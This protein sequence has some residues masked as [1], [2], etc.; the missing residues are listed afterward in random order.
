MAFEEIKPVQSANE[1]IDIAIRHAN[2][3]VALIKLKGD[4]L[5]KLKTKELRRIEIIRDVLLARLENVYTQFPIIKEL[6]PFYKEMIEITIGTYELKKELSVIIWSKNQ[7]KAFFRKYNIKLKSAKSL[8]AVY[9]AKKAYYGRISSVVKKINFQFLVNARKTLQSFPVIKS[10]YKQIAITGFP[11][12]GKST[13]L[14][15]ITKSKPEIAAYPFTTKGIMIGYTEKIQFLDTPGT[16]N[17]QNKM[18]YIELMAFLVMKHVAEKI[19]YIFD[20]TESYPLKDQIR[21][22]KRIKEFKKP[23]IIYLSKT[24]ILEKEKI[25]EFKEKYPKAVSDVKE[26]KKNLNN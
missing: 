19:I 20:L 13:L 17:R 2:K 26:L 14:S 12:V 15:K 24:D 6:T 16:L 4:R 21:L 18:N 9:A 10:K 3:K 22:L 1:Y 7:V 11:N 23:V 5:N 25:Q 8:N